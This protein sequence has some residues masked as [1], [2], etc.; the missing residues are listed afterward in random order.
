MPVVDNEAARD[1]KMRPLGNLKPNNQSP[2]NALECSFI[3]P[4]GPFGVA[5][6]RGQLAISAVCHDHGRQGAQSMKG[7]R[8]AQT[9]N[10]S[11]THVSTRV[12]LLVGGTS[13]YSP[14]PNIPITIPLICEILPRHHTPAL[15]G[16]GVPS[17]L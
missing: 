9:N 4:P 2:T 11:P 15:L 12:F 3:N 6:S 5:V 8:V 17:V 16:T 1:R 7:A 14:T 10:Q 13:R